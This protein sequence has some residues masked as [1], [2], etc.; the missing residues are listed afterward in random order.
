VEEHLHDEIEHARWLK[1]QIRA[2]EKR[3]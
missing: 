2:L 1:V 3:G